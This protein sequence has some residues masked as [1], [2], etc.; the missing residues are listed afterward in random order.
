MLRKQDVE[1]P[2]D[3]TRELGGREHHAGDTGHQIGEGAANQMM[4]EQESASNPF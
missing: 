2:P 1:V 4:E 3:A